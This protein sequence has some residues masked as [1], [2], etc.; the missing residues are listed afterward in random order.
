VGKYYNAEQVAQL[1]KKSA[2]AIR[3]V[4]AKH[5]IGTRLSREWVFTDEDIEQFKKIKRG[6]PMKPKG[7][8][9]SDPQA[10]PIEPAAPSE[11]AEDRGYWD[12]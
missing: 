10:Q 9:A 2:V 6:R 3:L 7:P 4:A 8:K 1:L 5:N 12:F 11:P